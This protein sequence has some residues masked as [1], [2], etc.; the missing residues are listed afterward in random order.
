MQVASNKGTATRSDSDKYDYYVLKLN[1]VSCCE[2]NWLD[3]HALHA[4]VYMYILDPLALLSPPL[5]P[6][7]PLA[8][9]CLNAKHPLKFFYVCFAIQ[10][11]IPSS[12]SLF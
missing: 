10:V 1:M 6:I 3:P 9:K 8:A 11:T 4:V 2:R 7:V 5:V 12:G